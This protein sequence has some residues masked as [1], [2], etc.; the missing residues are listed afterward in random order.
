MAEK[1]GVPHPAD[2]TITQDII[3]RLHNIEGQVRGLQRMVEE[4]QYCI[5]ILTQ[6]SAAR[7]ALNSVGMKVLRRHINTCLTT[8]IQEG[9]RN[10]EEMIEELMTVLSRQK[11]PE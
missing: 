9:G 4:D 2:D 8:A 1:K 10:Q 3:K 7:S 11:L 6:V 5:D